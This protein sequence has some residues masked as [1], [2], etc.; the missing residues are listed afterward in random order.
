M[1]TG[2]PTV[3]TYV[4]K[5]LCGLVLSMGTTVAVGQGS[6]PATFDPTAGT[7]HSVPASEAPT[8]LPEARGG[9]QTVVIFADDFEAPSLNAGWT[10]QV[11]NGATNAFW[12]LTTFAASS[13][14]RSVFCAA[15]GTA[16]VQAG[17]APYP[18]N[19]QTRM[20]YGPFSLADAQSG[21][22]ALNYY[23]DTEFNFDFMSVY[24]S[25]DGLQTFGGYDGSGVSG[26]DWAPLIMDFSQ[27]PT[28][29]N[30]LGA[31]EVY[32]VVAFNSDA[33][34]E[35]VG[36]FMDDVLI[37]KNVGVSPTTPPPTT[38]IPTTA[39]PTTTAPTTA[40][41]TTTVPTTVPPTTTAPT[42]TPPP[43]SFTKSFRIFN[44]GTQNLNIQSITKEKNSDWIFSIQPAA[45]F[46]VAPGK[47][48]LVSVSVIQTGLANG[49]Y[50]DTLVIA[51]NDPDENPYP[52]GVVIQMNVGTQPTPTASGTATPTVTPTSP[53]P[54]TPQPTTPVPVDVLR[55]IRELTTEMWEPISI[56]SVF[57][58]PTMEVR[59]D[60]LLISTN[61]N[62]TFG[63]F[64]TK[65]TIGPLG[66]GNY[67]LTANLRPDGALSGNEVYPEIRLRVTSENGLVNYL[68][69]DASTGGNSAERPASVYFDGP[70]NGR[71]GVS[72]DILRFIDNQRAGYVVTGFQLDPIPFSGT[73]VDI[74]TLAPTLANWNTVAIPQVF[75][76][77]IFQER[78][79]GLLIGTNGNE[80][81][82]FLQSKQTIGPL[83]PGVYQLQARVQ[84]DGQLP[85]GGAYPEIR[86]RV[87]GQNGLVNLIRADASTGGN[88]SART[89]TTIFE[90]TDQD[91][92]FGVSVDILRFLPNQAEGYVV[93]GFS[94]FKLQ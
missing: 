85:Q 62:N 9:Q 6:L 46:V 17:T 82:G 54:T 43:G 20:V 84:P 59:N 72:L 61:S 89:L 12:G 21:G 8:S 18:S 66:V 45:P 57:T 91:N 87:T 73:A 15:A 74:P 90:A 71:F 47:D 94:L 49:V 51:S 83:A 34:N 58:A 26:L 88:T 16:A 24:V 11:A 70:E 4:T 48:Q 78:A 5:F 63:F 92:T 2:D 52:G 14:T 30:I 81:F 19:M 53:L 31:P 67:R 64:Q 86:L 27:V 42:P 40:P 79:N 28:L 1:K 10:V 44:E 3:R 32:F 55:P 39:P 13:G 36:A 7:L 50:T 37:Q 25:V 22:I 65:Q 80:T 41:P 60:G 29:G 68:R 76:S 93:T 77:P 69:A 56:P 35:S 38:T 33:S 23:Y 75:T